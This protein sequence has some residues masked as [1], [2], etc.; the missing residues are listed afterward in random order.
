MIS[1]KNGGISFIL[2]STSVE[3]FFMIPFVKSIS[4]QLTNYN[5][6]ITS[7]RKILY[8]P[9]ISDEFKIYPGHGGHSTIGKE[10]LKY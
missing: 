4:R 2:Y 1:C 6:L 7:I 10:R 3:I 9:K 8:Y 5:N